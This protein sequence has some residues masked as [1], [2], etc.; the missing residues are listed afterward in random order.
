MKKY[1]IAYACYTSRDWCILQTKTVVKCTIAYTCHTSR[2]C[3]IY[4]ITTVTKCT[5]AYTCHTFR[6]CYYSQMITI[7]KCTIANCR[8][9]MSIYLIWYHQLH[10]TS[11]ISGY[12]N[13]TFIGY[14]ILIPIISCCLR[15]HLLSRRFKISCYSTDNQH[16]HQ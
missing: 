3:Y 15:C 14:L 11:I 7:R 8:H 1:I 9:W 2:D 6:D 13:F 16:Q 4:Q 12:R 10:R 5:I